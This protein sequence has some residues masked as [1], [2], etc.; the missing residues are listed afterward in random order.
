MN[1]EFSESKNNDIVSSLAVKCRR[2]NGDAWCTCFYARSIRACV[3]QIC[4]NDCSR[5]DG[6]E[7]ITGNCLLHSVEQSPS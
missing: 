3:C 1:D 4:H 2:Q 7:N 5:A 6:V